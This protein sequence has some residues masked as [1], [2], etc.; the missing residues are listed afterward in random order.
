MR[1]YLV[2]LDFEMDE[3]VVSWYYCWILRWMLALLFGNVVRF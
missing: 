1:C 2:M 3:C